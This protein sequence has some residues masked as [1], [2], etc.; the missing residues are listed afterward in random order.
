MTD[1][2]SWVEK[3]RPCILSCPSAF[4]ARH[5]F[6]NFW[7][8]TILPRKQHTLILCPHGK[9]ADHG[10]MMRRKTKD[11]DIFV[12]DEC[13]D[14]QWPR[15]YTKSK[16]LTLCSRA[17]GKRNLQ[18]GVQEQAPTLLDTHT[19]ELTVGTHISDSTIATPNLSPS[20]NLSNTRFWVFK[21]NVFS[22]IEISS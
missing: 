17:T 22:D 10:P 19:P 8:L 5:S 1:Q 20:I 6:S 13:W 7:S 2:K 21:K 16:Q 9:A 14:R 3:N 11:H 4:L 18:K 12:T 15:G